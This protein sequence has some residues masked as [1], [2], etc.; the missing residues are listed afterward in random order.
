MEI[1]IE[2][3]KNTCK[4]KQA[5]YVDMPVGQAFMWCSLSNNFDDSWK[6]LGKGI[7]LNDRVWFNLKNL[8]P[9]SLDSAS[10]QCY[11]YLL[12]VE[13]ADIKVREVLE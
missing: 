12:T 5:K 9:E 2:L 1:K 11:C 7:K 6:N 10:V 8:L 4:Y 13:S 3:A